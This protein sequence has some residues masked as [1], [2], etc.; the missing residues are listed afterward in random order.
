M[1]LLC[2]VSMFQP[3]HVCFL[4]TKKNMVIEGT[5]TKIIYSDSVVSLN[6]LYIHCPLE[7]LQ[8]P[9]LPL[10][11]SSY[12]GDL[13]ERKGRYDTFSDDRRRNI[14]YSGI[15]HT[16]PTILATYQEN[17]MTVITKK[18]SFAFSL[19]AFTSSAATMVPPVRHVSRGGGRPTQHST[20]ASTSS[21][22]ALSNVGSANY[23]VYLVKE[24]NRIEHEMIEYYKDFFKINH[25][26]NV[27][28]LR[29]QLKT[30]YIKV[31]QKIQVPPNSNTSE[32]SGD[33]SPTSS[34]HGRSLVIK[35]SGIWETET[36]VGITFKFQM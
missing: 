4:D 36:N 33:T 25:K 27:Y 24:L 19:D 31:I 26:I 5:F 23:N 18:V 10:S 22:H 20:T 28:S 6:G 21:L 14:G 32:R 7:P 35:I 9:S 11:S 16:K 17:G 34:N 3:Y 30:G 15:S 8:V 2:D 13:S 12:G 29:N 1:N